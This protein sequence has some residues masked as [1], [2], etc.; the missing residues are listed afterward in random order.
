MAYTLTD[1]DVNH[2]RR[3]SNMCYIVLRDYETY[4]SS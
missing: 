4:Y 1:V 3:V 2:G